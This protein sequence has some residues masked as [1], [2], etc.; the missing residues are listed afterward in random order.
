MSWGIYFGVIMA[1]PSWTYSQLEAYE[2]CPKK[3][4]H[5]RVLKDF[6]DPPNEYSAWGERVH[7][8]L[9]NRIKDGTPLPDGMTQW[10]GIAGKLEALPGEKL[11]EHKMAVDSAF[12]P[13]DWKQ[14]WS[15]GIIDLLVVHG[16][17][18]VVADHKTGKRK[19]TEQLELYAG[20]V[21]SHYPEVEE[22]TSCFIWLKEKRIDKQTYSREDVYS[23]WKG[24]LPRVTKLESSYER[25]SWLARPSGLCKGWCPV[26]SCEFNSRK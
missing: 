14:A 6:K 9:E 15:R 12:Q 20:Y 10:E 5:L 8:A 7:T 16:K 1:I 19:M 13:A 25:D 24:F 26:T 17:K 18:A 23:I 4:Y 3:F 2:T 21:F 22:V 11:T